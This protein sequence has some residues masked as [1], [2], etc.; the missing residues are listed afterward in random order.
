MLRRHSFRWFN[1][2]IATNQTPALTCFDIQRQNETVSRSNR[3]E[4]I[5][6][7]KGCLSRAGV[8]P[9]HLP[10]IVFQ[11]EKQFF[12]VHSFIVD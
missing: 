10:R 1:P 12:N 8:A 6:P 3:I 5:D 7:I 2:L 9:D 11:K 4:L